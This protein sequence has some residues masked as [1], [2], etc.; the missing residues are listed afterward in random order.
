[1]TTAML[2]IVLYVVFLAVLASFLFAFLRRD[3][4][5]KGN[6][7]FVCVSLIASAYGGELLLRFTDFLLSGPRQSVMSN[8]I[9]S[10]EKKKEAAKLTKKFGV[11]ID[12]RDGLEVGTDLRK[13]GVDTVPSIA[14]SYFFVRQPDGSIKSAVNIHGNE[15]IPLGGGAKKMK[16]VFHVNGC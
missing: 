4:E 7:A 15:I 2:A 10:T 16:V 14:P 12:T 13:R 11:E 5:F 3:P 9:A 1:M 6:S 8:V